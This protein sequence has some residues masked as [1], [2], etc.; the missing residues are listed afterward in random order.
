MRIWPIFGFFTAI[1][2]AA[3]VILLIAAR[4]D[5]VA[6]WIALGMFCGALLFGSITWLIARSE[7]A[8]RRF[9]RSGPIAPGAN[10][11]LG[12]RWN[13]E[14]YA[15]ALATEVSAQGGLVYTDPK[16][17]TIRVMFDPAASIRLVTRFEHSTDTS[18]GGVRRSWQGLFLRVRATPGNRPRVNVIDATVGARFDDSNRLVPVWNP[19]WGSDRTTARA[20][21]QANAGR[22]STG[23]SLSTRQ[24]EPLALA[25]AAEAGWIDRSEVPAQPSPEPSPSPTPPPPMSAQDVQA[26]LAADSRMA[27][28]I[29]YFIGGGVLAACVIATIIGLASGMPWWVSFI[30]IGSGLFFCL[31]FTLPVMFLQRA[32]ARTGRRHP[33]PPLS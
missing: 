11:P 32:D 6:G 3:T 33:R 27:F 15:Q 9:D 5:P 7:M 16:R 26:K 10:L 1:L 30:I 21:A 17:E 4:T 12:T 31:V 28:R 24:F 25:L 13:F 8:N 2:T 29:F 19:G 23:I 14:Q 20:I 22:S 18:P